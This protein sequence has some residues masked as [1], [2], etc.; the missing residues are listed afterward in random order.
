MAEMGLESTKIL[1]DFGVMPIHGMQ[2]RGKQFNGCQSCAYE[3]KYSDELKGRT[4]MRTGKQQQCNGSEY[5]IN[6]FG[7][8]GR[9][10]RE[11]VYGQAS[12]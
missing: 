7:V 5:F 12:N 6:K 2:N 11:G 3:P 10:V 9:K 8:K 4:C 1:T